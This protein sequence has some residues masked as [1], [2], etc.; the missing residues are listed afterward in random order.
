MDAE[1]EPED[2]WPEALELVEEAGLEPAAEEQ[3]TPSFGR[4]R[5]GLVADDDWSAV[6]DPEAAI[7]PEPVASL[8]QMVMPVAFE[9]AQPGESYA[10]QYD[11]TLDLAGF[12][13]V[14]DGFMEVEDTIEEA[15]FAAEPEDM[16]LADW[17]AA[18]RDLAFAAL[19]SE[20][21]SR[22]SLY[23]AIGRAYD[24]SLAAAEDPVGFAELV[25]DAGLAVQDRAPMT[26]LVK[27]VFG[28]NYDKTR[29]TEYAAA[30]GH[31]G[32]IGLERGALENYL[33]FAPGGLKGV[34]QTERQLRREEAGVTAAPRRPGE[35]LARKL[36]KLDTL[37]LSEVAT[38]GSEFTLLVARRLAS[39]E[40]VLLGEVGDDTALLERAARRLLA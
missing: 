32:R 28:A 12:A 7:E 33:L 18:A 15:P 21:R 37:P 20:D 30:L 5:R 11:G 27:L 4:R 24:F 6:P 26:P 29:L 13:E 34:V 31:A 1:D 16:A 25:A 36:R 40:V 8:S 3:P 39:G 14:D 2:A 9:A 38:Q 23:A 35:R 17:L 10:D 22:Q 19:N